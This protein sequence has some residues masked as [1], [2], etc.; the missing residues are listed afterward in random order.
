MYKPDREEYDY[1]KGSATITYILLVTTG[2]IIFIEALRSSDANNRGE[3]GFISHVMNLET[4]ISVIAT[5]F[6]SLFLKEFSDAEVNNT[7]IDWEKVTKYRYIDWSITTPIMLLVLCLYLANNIKSSVKIG[8]F[9]LVVALNYIML[10][11]GYLGETG[12]IDKNSS[13]LG[14][15]AAFGLIY[16]LIYKNY[17]TS[18]YSFANSALFWFYAIVWSFYGI[19]FYFDS[20]Y[21]N[22]ALN[23]LDVI[24]KCFVGLG[25]WAYYTKI[26]TT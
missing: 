23:I 18:K 5:Y 9:M 16:A 6:Y 17:M 24:S 4:A 20:G 22:T 13:L 8:F 25:L 11:F 1:N 19:V 7:P 3:S 2:V 21:K 10:A 14:G 26:I 15:F 12:Q